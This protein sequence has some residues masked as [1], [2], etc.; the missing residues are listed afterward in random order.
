MIGATRRYDLATVEDAEREEKRERGK[1]QWLVTPVM[2]RRED[3]WGERA[4]RLARMR[5]HRRMEA[6]PDPP[7][8]M[9]TARM[10]VVVAGR[11]CARHQRGGRPRRITPDQADEVLA[12]RG[13]GWTM[14]RIAESLGVGVG[15]VKTVLRG[16]A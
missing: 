9:P 13:L 10:P 11:G 12:L 6:I 16:R 15:S 4:I 7:I 1:R 3:P 14:K 8:R 2:R 5:E